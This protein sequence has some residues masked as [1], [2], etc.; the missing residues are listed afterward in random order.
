MKKQKK[1]KKEEKKKKKDKK[2]KIKSEKNE[3][4]KS[5]IINDEDKILLFVWFNPDNNKTIKLLYKA[6]KDGDSYKDFYKFCG[7]KGPL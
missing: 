2:E 1:K 3:I 6:S 4:F 5:D 7:N